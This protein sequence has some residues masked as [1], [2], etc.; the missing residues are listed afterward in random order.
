MNLALNK[1][2]ITYLEYNISPSPPTLCM[3]H[4]KLFPTLRTLTRFHGTKENKANRFRVAQSTI[5]WGSY[6]QKHDCRCSKI[7]W[8]PRIC[9]RRKADMTQCHME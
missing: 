8:I 7:K 1:A 4:Y 9:V 3:L 5:Y 2:V 6:L